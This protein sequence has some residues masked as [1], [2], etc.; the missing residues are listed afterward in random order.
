MLIGVLLCTVLG[1]M[2]RNCRGK[3]ED[4]DVGQMSLTDWISSHKQARVGLYE[5]RE[6]NFQKMQIEPAEA[7][8]RWGDKATLDLTFDNN[9]D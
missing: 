5:N 4:V 2:A 3:G 1:S 8:S 6:H 7:K 9:F